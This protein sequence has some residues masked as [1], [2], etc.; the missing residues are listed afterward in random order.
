MRWKVKC[1]CAENWAL[2]LT[3][4]E[5]IA[6][7]GPNT[8]LHF[9]KWKKSR[10]KIPPLL[11]DWGVAG[12]ACLAFDFMPWFEICKDLCKLLQF[13]NWSQA[14]LGGYYVITC[15]IV[16]VKNPKLWTY[17]LPTLCSQE[18]QQLQFMTNNLSLFT[19]QCCVFSRIFKATLWSLLTGQSTRWWFCWG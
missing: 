10:L 19:R 9:L 11:P 5:N 12:C 6:N 16:L 18:W 15:L 7:V 17:L 14:K 1:C 2:C 8:N 4:S 3:V 13:L